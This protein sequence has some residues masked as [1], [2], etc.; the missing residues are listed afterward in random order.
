MILQELN[1]SGLAYKLGDDTYSI[2]LFADD[3]VIIADTEQKLRE[4]I[5][6]CK[7]VC[8]SYDL[9]AN[10]KKCAVMQMQSELNEPIGEDFMWNSQTI[11]IVSEYT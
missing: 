1:A 2:Q 8:D 7:N 9:K 4:L 6:L 11:E 10:V 3:L 5:E